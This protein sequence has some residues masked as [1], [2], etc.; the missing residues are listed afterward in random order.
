M[1]RHCPHAHGPHAQL[2]CSQRHRPSAPAITAA[3]GSSVLPNPKRCRHSLR[4]LLCRRAQLQAALRCPAL[5]CAAP[6]PSPTSTHHL[7]AT[8][9]PAVC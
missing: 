5:P 1:Q 8:G 9:Q 6:A 7:A 3:P 4:Q 2:R